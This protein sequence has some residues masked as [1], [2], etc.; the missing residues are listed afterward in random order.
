M[1]DELGQA[2]ASNPF[3]RVEKEHSSLNKIC[4]LFRQIELLE[5]D[6]G[7]T[8]RFLAIAFI[9]LA[10]SWAA[11]RLGY[12][13][14]A[15]EF[16]VVAVIMHVLTRIQR[17]KAPAEA[18]EWKILR[19]GLMER[20]AIGLGTV[21]TL[22]F[23][24][25]FFFV[26]SARHDADQQMLMLRLLL[27]AF[28]LM[29]A[30]ASYLALMV[31]IRWDARQIEQESSLFGKRSVQFADIVQLSPLRWADML[32]ITSID[33]TRIYVP[34]YRNGADMLL[35]ELTAKLGLSHGNSPDINRT[36]DR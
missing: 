13:R 20:L 7:M 25:I 22:L 34:L 2:S 12:L 27:V 9:C 16:V 28:T 23:A 21:L 8:R 24:Y 32:R 4:Q 14:F 36:T 3:K 1:C 29:T 33:G 17:G 11:W 5:D 19:V 10:S 26:G 18:G 6:P 30:Y 15:V 35:D 31:T